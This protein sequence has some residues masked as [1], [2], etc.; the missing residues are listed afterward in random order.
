MP[1]DNNKQANKRRYSEDSSDESDDN[2]PPQKKTA[3]TEEQSRSPVTLSDTD[4]LS[5]LSGK[6]SAMSNGHSPSPVISSQNVSYVT[7]VLSRGVQGSSLIKCRHRAM[8]ISNLH[9]TI[10]L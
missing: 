9:L 4:R 3:C 8:L 7:S 5:S 1:N 10:I 6:I 2:S